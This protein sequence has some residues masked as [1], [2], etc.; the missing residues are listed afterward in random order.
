LDG[1]MRRDYPVVQGWVLLMS[2]C[3]ALIY[4]LTQI[5]GRWIDPRQRESAT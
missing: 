3:Q 5:A 4:G 1:V 2:V